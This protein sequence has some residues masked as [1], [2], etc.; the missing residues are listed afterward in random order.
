MD[1]GVAVI[2]WILCGIASF[3]IAR[4][5]GATNAGTWFVHGVLFGP[6][7]VLAALIGVKRALPQPPAPSVLPP[8]PAGAALARSVSVAD[9]LAKLVALREAGELS[10]AEFARQRLN[11]LGSA[12]APVTPTWRDAGAPAP[13][14]SVPLVT[15]PP[16]SAVAPTSGGRSTA[17]WIVI[18]LI[19]VAVVGGAF[20]VL[21]N[22][23]TPTLTTGSSANIPPAGSVW[24][25]DSFDSNTFEIRGRKSTVGTTEA[26]SF[27][28]HLTDAMNSEDLAIRVS[29]D[30]QLV[31]SQRVDATGSSDVWGF[32]PGP[33]F[34]AG[35]WR[36]ELTDIGGNVLA[37][38][39]ITATE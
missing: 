33:L 20:V 29:F 34:A 38:G 13:P 15:A 21:N 35:E 30:G 32:S 39:T 6:F 1:I 4:G 19:I 31:S 27:V 5:R 37:S 8:E 7:G 10:P 24:F 11:V 16:S 25:G 22:G 36:Y 28:A 3:A 14:T 12:G 2:I 9:E 17:E 23:R 26:F 18:G